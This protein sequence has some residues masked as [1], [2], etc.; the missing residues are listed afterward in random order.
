MTLAA[1]K[2]LTAK[3][4]TVDIHAWFKGLS[5]DRLQD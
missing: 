5:S 2:V 4:T 1:K 3:N